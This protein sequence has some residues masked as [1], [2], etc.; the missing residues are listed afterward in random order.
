M[1]QRA[2]HYANLV[3]SVKLTFL[4]QLTDP[5]ILSQ[6][7]LFNYLAMRVLLRLAAAPSLDKHAQDQDYG[8]GEHFRLPVNLLP[9]P[10]G[11]EL[12]FRM[13][14][15]YFAEDIAEIILYVTRTYPLAL[16]NVATGPHAFVDEL[17][18]FAVVFLRSASGANTVMISN[19]SDTDSSNAQQRDLSRHAF[20]RNP[21]L[22]A[23]W[24]EVLF[25]LTW[26]YGSG[27]QVDVVC[28]NAFGAHP[29]AINHL[30][31]SLISFYVGKFCY[32]LLSD[33]PN[34]RCGKNWN[35]IAIL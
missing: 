18:S 12:S 22:I 2:E 23:K 21:Y 26:D 7:L 15:E 32:L 13:L 8:K 34:R 16:V 24:V 17:I 14:P 5:K 27:S 3:K 19:Y 25:S 31:A 33:E 6:V 9:L 4:I 1:I 20:I 30:P 28:K 29:I 10:K 11:P 35:V